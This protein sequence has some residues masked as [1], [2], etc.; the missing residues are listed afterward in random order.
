V[1]AAVAHK[2][3]PRAQ[4]AFMMG[5]DITKMAGYSEELLKEVLQAFFDRG[6]VSSEFLTWS[7]HFKEA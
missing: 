6:L 2:M 5:Q 7:L 4:S 1:E 3:G